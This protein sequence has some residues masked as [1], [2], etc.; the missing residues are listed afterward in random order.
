[1]SNDKLVNWY[2][3]FPIWWNEDG[4][5]DSIGSVIEDIKVKYL[6]NLLK[7]KLEQPI[8]LW[9]TPI[10]EN[11]YIKKQT[12]TT[13][14][15][16]IEIEAPRY[17]TTGKITINF[18]CKKTLQ[19]LTILMND[20]D[21]YK[22]NFPIKTGTLVF[23]ME[24]NLITYDD[25]EVELVQL[26]NGFDHYIPSARD[27]IWDDGEPIHNEVVRL[28][29]STTS[30]ETDVS[31]DVEM[32]LN[33]PVFKLEQNIKLASIKEAPIEE[34]RLYAYYDFPFN[35]QING[36][37]YVYRKTYSKYSKTTFDMITKS[38]YTKKFYVEVKFTILNRP[39]TIGFPQTINTDY[40]DEFYINTSLDKWGNIFGLPRREYKDGINEI[41]PQ[42]DYPKTYPPYYPYEVEQD[43]WYEKRLMHEYVWNINNIDV[44]LIKD[45]N[46]EPIM[47]LTS[48][49]PYVEDLTIFTNSTPPTEE[50]YQTQK[51]NFIPSYIA[52]NTSSVKYSQAPFDNI[53]NLLEDDDT[54]ASVILEPKTNVYITTQAYK[55][56][57]LELFYELKDLPENI[58]IK[59]IEFQIENECSDN[60]SRKYNDIRTRIEVGP[61]SEKSSTYSVEE[62]HPLNE[63]K[64]YT[65]TKNHFSFGGENEKYGFAN[66]INN[67]NDL[68]NYLATNG[69][70]LIFSLEND[71]LDLETYINIYNIKL[72]IHYQKKKEE[73]QLNTSINYINDFE[74]GKVANL[75]IDIKNIG[76]KN[77]DS[78]INIIPTKD[79]IVSSER[80][81]VNLNIGDSMSTSILVSTINNA[82]TNTY[83]IK[84]GIYDILVICNDIMKHNYIHITSANLKPSY[85]KINRMGCLI[86]DTVTFTA[87]I[88]NVEKI[89]IVGGKVQ[90]YIS[91]YYLGESTVSKDGVAKLTTTIPS[92]IKNG[93]YTYE[94]KYSGNDIY[95]N[96]NA[97]S[98]ILINSNSTYIKV[99]DITQKVN[100]NLNITANV[101]SLSGIVDEG[102]IT[103][104]IDDDE[105]GRANVF[106]GEVY[107]TATLIYNLKN[108]TIGNYKLTL[109][110]EG[111]TNFA[112]CKQTV[113]L[114]LI[115]GKTTTNVYDVYSYYGEESTILATI[116]DSK[117]RKVTS[118]KVTFTINEQNNNKLYEE[119]VNLIEGTGQIK[120]IVPKEK[121]IE[122]TNNFIISVSYTDDNKI[123]DDSTGTGNLIINK[124]DTY[125]T[126]SS[127]I[128]YQNETLDILV[129][130]MDV[131]NNDI[132]NG[133]V[134]ATFH[135]NNTNNILTSPVENGYAKFLYNVVTFDNEV[136]ESLSKF[137]FETIDDNLYRVYSGD[138]KDLSMRD[139]IV[140]DGILYYISNDGTENIPLFPVLNEDKFEFYAEKQITISSLKDMQVDFVYNPEHTYKKSYLT[141]TYIDVK[142]N[143]SYNIVLFSMKKT[144]LD[145][146][147]ITAYVNDA[148]TGNP[149]TSGTVEFLIDDKSIGQ[150]E[151][152][153]GQAILKDYNCTLIPGTY[154]IKAQV[155]NDI[156]TSNKLTISKVSTT[157]NSSINKCFIKKES[158]ISVNINCGKYTFNNKLII[159]LLKTNS[160]G[161]VNSRVKYNELYL[162]KNDYSFKY[163]IPE[164]IQKPYGYGFEF[165][166]EEDS[167]F[168]P[169]K[170]TLLL[171]PETLNVKL[172]L[173]N[174]KSAQY[175]DANL[176]V[177]VKALDLNNNELDE[178]ISE[179]E[180]EIYDGT[181]LIGSST[182]LN[183][184]AIINW[185]PKKDAG[186]YKL[187]IKYIKDVNYNNNQIQANVTIIEELNEIYVSLNGDDYNN[188]GTKESPFKTLKQAIT[189]I[190]PNGTINILK[191]LYVSENI[192]INKN[193]N[194]LGENDV[195]FYNPDF[196]STNIDITINSEVLF[197]NI[198]FKAIDYYYYI[199]NYKTLNCEFCVFE[200]NCTITNYGESSTSGTLTN[201]NLNI[202][203]SVILGKINNLNNG[204]YT[205]NNNWWGSNK[206]DTG[207]TIDNYVIL[208]LT[209]D[210]DIIT[211][212]EDSKIT[213]TFVNN[214]D[215]QT[216]NYPERPININ[217]YNSTYTDFNGDY[218]KESSKLINNSYTLAIN[219]LSNEGWITC[220]VDNEFLILQVYP[221]ENN[222]IIYSNDVTVPIDNRVYIESFVK[223][224]YTNKL[225]TE[226]NLQYTLIDGD[227]RSQI[228]IVNLENNSSIS[229]Y[230]SDEL[231]TYKTYQIEIEYLGTKSN[232]KSKT[233]INLNVIKPDNALFVSSGSS[234]N[235]INN[236]TYTAPFK[237][238]NWAITQAYQ[239]SKDTIYLINYFGTENNILNYP[240]PTTNEK[241]RILNI[242][243][244]GTT[245]TITLND[246]IGISTYETDTFNFKNIIFT[247]C[248]NNILFN[249]LGKININKCQ[250]ENNTIT[251]TFIQNEGTF[252]ITNSTIYNNEI[253]K[254]VNSETNCSFENNW[255]G[256]ND[257]TKIPVTVTKYVTMKL[258]SSITKTINIDSKDTDVILKGNVPLLTTTLTND[259][260]LLSRNV[261]YLTE[262]IKL[263]DTIYPAYS[264]IPVSNI[265][266]NNISHTLLNTN[267]NKDNIINI[268]LLDNNYYYLMDENNLNTDLFFSC[269]VYNIDGK[270]TQGYVYFTINDNYT[271]KANVTV[272]GIAGI[273]INNNYSLGTYPIKLEYYNL[274]YEKLA[275]LETTFTIMLNPITITNIDFQN[276][277]NDPTNIYQ[278]HINITTL[279]DIKSESSKICNIERL[280]NVNTKI[281]YQIDTF[282]YTYNK[283]NI[284]I[285]FNQTLPSGVY[286]LTFSLWDDE[287]KK[288][289]FTYT[290]EIPL[291]KTYINF[292]YEFLSPND[293]IDLEATITDETNRLIDNGLVIFYCDQ[294]EI[295]TMNG[296]VNTG[297]VKN[298]KAYVHNYVTPNT[299]SY[300]FT[301]YYT[302][303][304]NY[305]DNAIK[306]NKTNV[307]LNPVKFFTEDGSEL[308]NFSTYVNDIK[309]IDI[310][311]TDSSFHKI[312]NGIIKW[313]INKDGA[314]VL[315]KILLVTDG[316]A[317]FKTDIPLLTE[318]QDT[319]AYTFTFVN[320]KYAETTKT[321]NAYL[322]RLPINI[323]Y[324]NLSLMCQD[325]LK[326]TIN[327]KTSY[328]NTI[329]NE[330]YI[331]IT[332][333]NVKIAE[334]AV[335]NN[336]V[337]NIIIKTPNL[338]TSGIH[339]AELKYS[340]S[341][342]FENK[343]ISCPI[344]IIA[345]NVN[346]TPQI[347]EYY[348]N[349]NF[350]YTVDVTN[351][352]N[353]N[354]V[355]YGSVT[356]Y[357]DGTK[358]QTVD[359]KNGKAEFDLIFDTIKNYNINLLYNEND[360]FNATQK[361]TELNIKKIPISITA[362]SI[363][364]IINESVEATIQ[365]SN[366]LN[367]VVTD[368]VLILSSAQEDLITYNI[369]ENSDN[370]QYVRFNIPSY[371]LKGDNELTIKYSNSDY[372]ED[373]LIKANV[374][375]N[376][377]PTEVTL[378]EINNVNIPEDLQIT[379]TFNQKVNGIAYFYL[380]NMDNFIDMDLIEYNETSQKY[381]ANIIYPL[382]TDITELNH[383][384]YI[385]YNG[386]DQYSA[387]SNKVDFT[388]NKIKS[389]LTLNTIT[390][391]V[392]KT[393]KLIATTTNILTNKNIKFYINNTLI[394]S[395]N[396]NPETKT[397][398]LEYTL[399]YS[400]STENIVGEYTIKA[401]LNQT[402][403]YEE[404]I[405]T[406]T[407]TINPLNITIED[408][409]QKYY[410]GSTMSLK[411]KVIDSNN[412]EITSGTLK[413]IYSN[414]F[415][416]SVSP[417]TNT[418][419]INLSDSDTDKQITI[420]YTPDTKYSNIYNSATIT[421]DIILNK[422]DIDTDISWSGYHNTNINEEI[423]FTHSTTNSELKDTTLECFI[424]NE[425]IGSFN[426][427][428]NKCTINTTIPQNAILGNNDVKIV[429][430]GNSIFNTTTITGSLTL[431]AKDILYVS[432]TG[433]I[434]NPGTL[435]S[436]YATINEALNYISNT[437]TIYLLPGTYQENLTINKNIKLINND[438]NT[439]VI[440]TGTST[441]QSIIINN[442]NIT[443]EG[444]TFQDNTTD[445]DGAGIFNSGS[446]NIKKCTFKNLNISSNIARNGGAIYSNST[447]NIINS[448]FENN[449]AT[450]MGGAIY[451]GSLSTYNLI[452]NCTFKNN[453]GTVHGGAIDSYKADNLQITNCIFDTNTATN[454]GAIEIAGTAIIKSNKFVNNN[455]GISNTRGSSLYLS[456]GLVTLQKNIIKDIPYTIYIV[457]NSV[458][459]ASY[460][461]YNTNDNPI[462]Q[463]YG[464]V[465]NTYWIKFIDGKIKYTDGTN[466]YDY[467]DTFN[468]V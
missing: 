418:S 320:E 104:Y 17:W 280:I 20:T 269:K 155:N 140:T 4:F 84:N 457:D 443:L 304:N 50:E 178:N 242:I 452:D 152:I 290:Y 340:N 436:P 362:N 135:D 75:L 211:V 188:T 376:T 59:G 351:N 92:N 185:L 365:L 45:S 161:T 367:N 103:F 331:T 78:N 283:N 346:L 11:D 46:Q 224:I 390:T 386:N 300:E 127:L 54:F 333:D 120:Y 14:P 39:I 113:N 165:V 187:T 134:T 137:S 218:S 222:T 125:M 305:Y 179:G 13:L 16:S 42:C 257:K 160:D 414:D 399:P 454:G 344:N 55:T 171:N 81:P 395:S 428:N 67:T 203:Q 130:V 348:P 404:V 12:I 175:N 276:T 200:N 207:L 26:G 70:H 393:I 74:H 407:L 444:I 258:D 193:V 56:Q 318:P 150:A 87:S 350:I 402:A 82:E 410:I 313:Y 76:E 432:T 85:M 170:S 168:L 88:Q 149:T 420:T 247:H 297:I 389:N 157:I 381:E 189:C 52:Q 196:D 265:T 156:F 246:I 353:N 198:I 237:T 370:K 107:G 173:E 352:L 431:N 401:I 465:N 236:G 139:F 293:T 388:I 65:M 25:Y 334:Q 445:T 270:I 30:A 375:A 27:A 342:N 378:N 455:S 371:F 79:L 408:I 275:T 309:T 405:A 53:E 174:F 286:Q 23:D 158:T 163:T 147:D 369:T 126:H 128:C 2:R 379:A 248:E 319:I 429:I 194:I 422:N 279:K 151:I 110:Y 311:V 329:V 278:T 392:G 225:I 148:D 217:A 169:S 417:N 411:N 356:L 359:V 268:E 216:Y 176:T 343:I 184:Q 391:N 341:I 210:N 202:K 31:F 274:N 115:G 243:G 109:V 295:N 467:T 37:R 442:G 383:T 22:I 177:N 387:C 166:I 250:L 226:G 6:M 48:I 77:V 267:K 296:D 373:N 382:S 337:S 260:T 106:A 255:W 361:S 312:N 154:L 380:D 317:T 332:L 355:D 220:S 421:K 97:F 164:D 180:I 43:Y 15:S 206:P 227:K 186:T 288:Q 195:Y 464:N 72:I 99:S 80:L 447:M 406:N 263:N 204:L 357:I 192:T 35:K 124:I 291:M 374:I 94:A 468:E 409:T 101:I 89:P 90:F 144:Y 310:Y 181:V 132:N 51:Q 159:N 199:S 5:L 212:G 466:D 118:G 425:S 273:I 57:E 100:T 306:I 108:Y 245:P 129:H 253:N 244:I 40:N 69:L 73:I 448:T 8:Q 190:K 233:T 307:G 111:T 426:I 330:G 308:S 266:Q 96:V 114:N 141:S 271:E 282:S 38:F 24:N 458:V 143:P 49:D 102:R 182:V 462:S 241:N 363:S 116:T 328:T 86:T 358:K 460:N 167:I 461:Y 10:Q 459:N 240:A 230:I 439:Q 354:I 61:Y 60:S 131:N 277:K 419:A 364:G 136:W 321:I 47:S 338:L 377:I 9:L 238:L 287:H 433:L 197:K 403:I 440:L 451:L 68:R 302:G 456:E 413:Y 28:S 281:E 434:T 427:T 394:G 29:F 122:E 146:F 36:W 368:G 234:A 299:G 446:L 183:N 360:K 142:T 119:T 3:H 289:S 397:A 63:Q 324:D 298:G 366:P 213:A 449:H 301:A 21:G 98:T 437:G 412:Q 400:N 232:Y 121:V 228:G 316:K 32:K 93:L 385:K 416:E 256:T 336:S 191:G 214:K 453:N 105:I 347:T 44:A 153:N 91:D 239:Q 7:S 209:S 162:S 327:V 335:T 435:E 424:N 117:N 285:K 229:T 384:I 252:S 64:I 430:Q 219:N 112:Y 322:N 372:F 396:I 326:T 315:P 66:T 172:S 294:S 58:Y 249:N 284:D 349:K 223:N 205:L 345:S 259:E 41:I 123:Y 235:D 19:N 221:Y 438:I 415:T 1:M 34:V 138:L 264:C 33:K 463:F 133:T 95:Q 314:T 261:K 292:K 18:N 423:I 323:T 325:E 262:E 83:D 339:N 272:N 254:F 215:S 145:T 450:Y 231:Y 398:E 201:S 71:D 303:I 251:D 62:S 441:K 208:K